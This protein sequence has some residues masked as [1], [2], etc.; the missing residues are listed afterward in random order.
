[1]SLDLNKMKFFINAVLNLFD[2]FFLLVPNTT[3]DVIIRKCRSF[4]FPV[5]RG[6]N[7]RSWLYRMRPSVVHNPFKPFTKI[8]GGES[9]VKNDWDDTYPNPN[10]VNFHNIDSSVNS[11]IRYNALDDYIY[12]KLFNFFA[13]S[14]F[15]SPSHSLSS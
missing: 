5:P 14:L 6:Q 12:I 13:R 8:H 15:F 9:Y 10:Q 3:L 1:M 2:F 11:R 4:H 7:K